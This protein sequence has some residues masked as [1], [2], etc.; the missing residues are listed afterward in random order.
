MAFGDR[1]RKVRE[2]RGLTLKELAQMVG[3]S[4]A[5]AQRY[6]SGAI[7]NP[8]QP[9][10]SALAR[11]LDVDVNYLMG[12]TGA[13]ERDAGWERPLTEA[14]RAANVSTQQAVCNVL[15]I[16]HVVPGPG[17]PMKTMLVYN[18]PAAA[19]V[20]LYAESDFEHIDFPAADIPENADFG[21]RVRGDS[22]SPTI[23][24]GAIVWVHKQQELQNDQIGIFM[25]RD[26]A[27]CKRFIRDR[28]GARLTSDNKAYAP[29]PL[30]DPEGTRLVGRVLGYR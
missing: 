6:E 30:K 7:G 24:D 27:V 15:R 8:K 3:V 23:A 22:M 21:I 5:T 20:P 19:G 28:R 2:E 10:L 16:P 25:L 12:F 14:Y 18:F 1:V 11:A 9:R 29:I 13:R 17:V 4:E 26:E